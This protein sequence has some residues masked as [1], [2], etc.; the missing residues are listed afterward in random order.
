MQAPLVTVALQHTLHRE[1]P[2]T[3]AMGVSVASYD[4][5]RLVLRAPL[6]ANLNHQ[7]TAFAGSLN[8]L[9]TVAGWGLL[10]LLVEAYGVPA[11][12]VI[13][14]AQVEYRRPVTGDLVAISEVPDLAARERFCAALSRRGR[15]RIA[16]ES[17]IECAPGRIAVR[18]RGRYVA[19]AS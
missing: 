11:Q 17:R 18:F 5:F 7:H 9:A 10:H 13:Q 19:R 15:G 2:L 14:D 3:R 6:A 12:V 16:L 4:G 1:I 8:A